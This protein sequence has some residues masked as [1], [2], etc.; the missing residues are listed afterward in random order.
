MQG[1]GFVVQESLATI[2]ADLFQRALDFREANTHD[3]EDYAEFGEVVADGFAN[4]WWC[5]DET[6]EAKIKGDTKA[7]VR[8]IPLDQEPGK[9]TCIHCGQEA[10]VRAIFAR[11]Y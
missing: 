8:C 4:S 9:S 11:A 5:E 10:R 6:C 3:P 2:Q 7:T 1:L